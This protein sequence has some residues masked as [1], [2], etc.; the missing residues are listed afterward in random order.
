[1]LCSKYLTMLKIL[2]K[3]L[4][5]HNNFLKFNCSNYSHVIY[6]IIIIVND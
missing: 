1:M 2:F 6:M 4:V 5:Y 3:V